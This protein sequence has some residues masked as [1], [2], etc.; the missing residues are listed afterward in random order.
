MEKLN[1]FDLKKQY[2]LAKQRLLFLNYEGTLVSRNQ[3]TTDRAVEQLIADLSS[4]AKNNV[5]V[6]SDRSVAALGD[7]F[8]N[9]TV[10]L[11]AES[12]GFMKSPG[13]EWRALS[14]FYMAW[15]EPVVNALRR[16]AASYPGSCLIEKHFSVK[17]KF[18]NGDNQLSD[19]ERRQLDVAFRMLS[20]QFEI[21]INHANGSVEFRSPDVSKSK[22]AA[23]WLSLNGPADFILAIGSDSTDEELFDTIGKSYTTVRVGY[24]GIS[25]ARYYVDDRSNVLALL[26]HLIRPVNKNSFY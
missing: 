6:I 4:D 5:A 7:C 24:T 10:T 15:K 17:W 3:A 9:N 21:P 1:Q 23:S 26:E 25:Q 13:G 22:F 14:D 18:D 11:V 19:T 16:L 20:I 2:H 8:L 12:G